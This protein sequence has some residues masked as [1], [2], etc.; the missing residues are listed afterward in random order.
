MAARTGDRGWGIYYLPEILRT[1]VD[2]FSSRDVPPPTTVQ[3]LRPYTS[4]LYPISTKGRQHKI[5]NPSRLK[6]TPSERWIQ[7][8]ISLLKW[9]GVVG[10]RD[11]QATGSLAYNLRLQLESSRPLK[12]DAKEDLRRPST[13]VELLWP[14]KPGTTPAT[15]CQSHLSGPLQGVREHLNL[16]IRCKRHAIS[17]PLARF[18]DKVASP[19]LIASFYLVDRGLR[20]RLPGCSSLV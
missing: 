5:R 4:A 19:Y 20:H 10:S 11:F 8:G 15:K 2:C 18:K 3:S 17:H 7:V 6:S 12:T 1:G 13:L 16:R 14:S 9:G